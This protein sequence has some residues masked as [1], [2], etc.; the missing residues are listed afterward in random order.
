MNTIIAGGISRCEQYIKR[1]V[2]SKS[3]FNVRMYGLSRIIEFP[4]SDTRFRFFGTEK[5]TDRIEGSYF[6][7]LVRKEIDAYIEKN[8]IPK[9]H[10]KPHI[11]LFH[12]NNIKENFNKPLSAIDINSCYWT[13]AYNLGYISEE[14]FQRGIKS[15]KKM[16]LLVSIGSLNKLPLIQVYKNGKFKK[17]YLDH[18]YSDRYS[19][20]FWNI[21]DVV[22][23]MCMEIY[24]M[25][26]D[27]FY[28]WITDCVHVSQDKKEAVEHYFEAHNYGHK[29]NIISYESCNNGTVGWYDCK[30]SKVKTM[31]YTNRTIYEPFKK[32]NG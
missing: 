2:K 6:V 1:Y 3:D 22:Y 27:D 14:L 21:I 30:E 24:D 17:Q 25:L 10:H 19:P 11:Q 15:N 28:A 23:N 9:I 12:T 7:T 8:G 13:T 5:K 26:G 20:F 32:W 4:N 16:G 31:G 29:S 18:E